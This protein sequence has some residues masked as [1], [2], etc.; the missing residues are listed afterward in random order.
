M[1]QDKK[2]LVV[3]DEENLRN[4]LC[5]EIIKAGYVAIPAKDGQEGIDLAYKEH[6]DLVLLDLLM[7]KVMGLNVLDKIR[8][9][10]WGKN[11]PVI[12]LTN[13]DYEEKKKELQ[14][15]PNCEY[16]IKAS[17]R[18]HDVVRKVKERINR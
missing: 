17:W 14:D 9:D 12:I 16:L 15:D 8:K 18:L 10:E 1:D 13:L 7:P 3:E 2:I 6:P 5:K 11:V 4:I